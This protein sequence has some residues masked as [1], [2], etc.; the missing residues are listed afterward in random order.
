MFDNLLA[1][2][3]FPLLNETYKAHNNRHVLQRDKRD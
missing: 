2:T 3:S 1:Y